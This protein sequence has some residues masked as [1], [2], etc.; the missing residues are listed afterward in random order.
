MGY[1]RTPYLCFY[2]N[3]LSDKP[4]LQKWYS[5]TNGRLSKT[6]IKE[7]L[8]KWYYSNYERI[9]IRHQDGQEA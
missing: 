3:S 7:D 4:G 8:Y 9:C 1:Q 5:I 2:Q 6:A